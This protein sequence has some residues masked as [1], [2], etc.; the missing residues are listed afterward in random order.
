ME[1]V[2]NRRMFQEPIYAK[3]GTYVKQYKPTL[4]QILNFYNAG[5]DAEGEPADMEAFQIAI[6]NARKANEAGLFEDGEAIDTGWFGKSLGDSKKDKEDLQEFMKENEIKNIYEDTWGYYPQKGDRAFKP[7]DAE[8]GFLSDLLTKERSSQVA[9][10]AGDYRLQGLQ[11]AEAEQTERDKINQAMADTKIMEEALDLPK[12]DLSLEGNKELIDQIEHM[13]RNINQTAGAHAGMSLADQAATMKA[14]MPSK[15]LSEEEQGIINRRNYLREYSDTFADMDPLKVE[16]L[17]SRAATSDQGLRIPEGAPLISPGEVKKKDIIEGAGSVTTTPGHE[18]FLN[19]MLNKYYKENPEQRR[20]QGPGPENVQTLDKWGLD[21]FEPHKWDWNLKSKTDRGLADEGGRVGEYFINE[22]G[23]IERKNYPFE[24]EQKIEEI[25]AGQEVDAGDRQETGVI[26]SKEDIKDEI[27]KGDKETIDKETIEDKIIKGADADEIFTEKETIEKKKDGYFFDH[28]PDFDWDDEQAILERFDVNGNG[29][30]DF[31]EMLKVTATRARD[32]KI[33]KKQ[34]EKRLEKIEK[35]LIEGAKREDVQAGMEAEDIKKL[36][37]DKTISVD[38]GKA[39]MK[40][41]GEEEVKTLDVAESEVETGTEKEG[42][43]T[44]QLGAAAESST[45][46]TETGGW[47]SE[48]KDAA[49]QAGFSFDDMIGDGST[50]DDDALEMMMYGLRLATTPG[51]FSDAA[52]ENAKVYLENKIK[53]NYKT[54]AAKSALKK[55][56]FLKMLQGNIDL[57]KWT[58]EQAYKEGQKPYSESKFYTNKDMDKMLSNWSMGNY[59]LD[60]EGA[61]PGSAEYGIILAMKDEITKIASEY[62]K[63][64]EA[65]P[66]GIV[67]LAWGRVNDRFEI[68]PGKEGWITLPLLGE[69]GEKPGKAKVKIPIISV[70]QFDKIQAKFPNMSKPALIALLQ[71][72]VNIKGRGMVKFNTSLIE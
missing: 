27:I 14:G 37:E 31:L 25:L 2:L 58:A 44:D 6:E 11:Q 59:K 3:S 48:I 51:K 49:A 24:A 28:D 61:E 63:Q 29:K 50:K 33:K 45:T 23:D 13:K 60:L 8:E 26:T 47:S 66:T 16:Q 64:G 40:P 5:F 12:V 30:L 35:P 70:N 53:R 38:Q 62:K 36:V 18:N 72:G 15:E 19:D 52:M 43:S 32:K 68:I 20:I 9:Q 4:E 10:E 69:I 34:T 54:A 17:L 22:K 1:N 46:T 41:H 42:T 21:I 7:S 57:K 67:H 71:S 65:P 55:S 39:L 56:I